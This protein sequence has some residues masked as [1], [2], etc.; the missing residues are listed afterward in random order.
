MSYYDKA[1]DIYDM[2]AQGKLL[3]AFEKYYHKDVEMVEATG[4]TRKGKD[5][6]RKFQVEFMGMIKEV[7]GSGVRA[8]TSNEKEATTMVES[9]M[10]VT[11]KDGKRNVMEEVAVQK[12]KGDQIVHERF[13]YNMGK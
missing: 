6:N 1:K 13:Y 10:D 9:W 4:E 3:E 7:H 12:W 5:A 11:L 8:F 2:L